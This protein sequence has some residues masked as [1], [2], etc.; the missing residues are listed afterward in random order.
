MAGGD[1][2]GCDGVGAVDYNVE[3][4]LVKLLLRGGQDVRCYLQCVRYEYSVCVV[5]VV[6]YLQRVRYEYSV[7]SVCCTV[8]AACTV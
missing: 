7:C 4:T 3:A 5:C 1:R 6:L 8:P 2:G